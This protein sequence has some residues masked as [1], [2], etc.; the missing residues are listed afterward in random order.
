MTRMARLA[1]VVVV[2]ACA[3][4]A[5]IALAQRPQT[6]AVTSPEVGADG[7]V[8]FRVYAPQAQSVRLATPGDIREVGTMPV[9]LAKGENGVWEATVGPIAPGAYRYAFAI[10]S[11]PTID[12]RNPLTTESL[13]SA[14]S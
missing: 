9:D 4:A 12:P 6:P 7:K 14:W 8:T 3:S 13:N 2:M 11:V 10:D 5:S 1:T